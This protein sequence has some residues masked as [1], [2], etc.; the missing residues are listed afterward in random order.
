MADYSGKNKVW[1]RAAEILKKTYGIDADVKWS[2]EE[3][4]NKLNSAS[5]KKA[6]ETKTTEATT[7]AKAEIVH[8]PSSQKVDVSAPVM[9]VHVPAPAVT[10]HGGGRLSL[11]AAFM[12][13]QAF[14]LGASAAYILP[15]VLLG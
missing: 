1:R 15:R 6:E 14:A 8:V 11:A 9:N 7:T 12:W 13:V 5:K 4:R 10:V 3:L 2:L